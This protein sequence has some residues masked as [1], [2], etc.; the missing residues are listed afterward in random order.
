VLQGIQLAVD[1]GGVWRLRST[2]EAAHSAALLAFGSDSFVEL[3]SA[4][5]V[6]GAVSFPVLRSRNVAFID[7][8]EV[9]CFY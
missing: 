3:L 9:C 5:V 2:S 7:L 6:A 4:S 8:P 1:A